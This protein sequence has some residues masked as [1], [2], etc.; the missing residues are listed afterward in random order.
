VSA[1]RESNDD[2][3]RVFMAVREGIKEIRVGTAG[4]RAIMVG[5]MNEL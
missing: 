3:Q 1:K 4:V 2:R 5:W